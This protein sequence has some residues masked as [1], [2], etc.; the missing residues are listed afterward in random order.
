MALESNPLE[1]IW[2]TEKVSSQGLFAPH[3]SC[4]PHVIFLRGRQSWPGRHAQLDATLRRRASF[5]FRK[6]TETERE[7]ITQ[8]LHIN[9]H[10]N[11][12]I[13]SRGLFLHPCS[14]FT[15][16]DSTKTKFGFVCCVCKYF[17]KEKKKIC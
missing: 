10:L 16:T 7:I 5:S 1:Q 4:L 3:R 12:V 17:L 6:E 11:E 15:A 13:W 14:V 9:D 2:V 8:V